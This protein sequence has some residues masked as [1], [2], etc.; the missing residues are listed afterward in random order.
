MPFQIFLQSA[1]PF[2]PQ[3]CLHLTKLTVVV[4]IDHFLSSCI[5]LYFIEIVINNNKHSESIAKAIQVP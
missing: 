1:H 4:C 2:P 5:F 3:G